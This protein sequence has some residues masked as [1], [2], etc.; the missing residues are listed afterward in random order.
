MILH[1]VCVHVCMCVRVRKWSFWTSICINPWIYPM[2]LPCYNN[3][4]SDNTNN[5]NP[6]Q[7]PMNGLVDLHLMVMQMRNWDPER[8]SNSSL[9]ELAISWAQRPVQCCSDSTTWMSLC[10]FPNLSLSHWGTP[11]S[12]QADRVE[13]QMLSGEAMD[14]V[15][16]AE[17]SSRLGC[18]DLCGVYSPL[19]TREAAC[20]EGSIMAAWSSIL[21]GCH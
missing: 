14:V 2:D 21:W 11:I 3:I 19:C 7:V 9:R 18:G 5:H 1:P 8:W 20:R 13:P 17:G 16:R 6:G 12:R 15:T 10:R 4:K